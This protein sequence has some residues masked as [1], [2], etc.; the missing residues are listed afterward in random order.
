MRKKILILGAQSPIARAT[1]AEFARQGASLY[2]AD[3]NSEEISRIA[4]DLWIRMNAFVRYGSFD[5]SEYE[6]HPAF[7]ASVVEEMDGIDGVVV[8]LDER[9]SHNEA[10]ERFLE[11]KRIIEINYLGIVSVLTAAA[12]YLSEERKG[13]IIGVTSGA[14]D[15]TNLG[16]YLY[17]SAKN[18]FAHFLDGLRKRLRNRDVRVI[19]V[20]LKTDIAEEAQL[21]IQITPQGIGK[22][23]AL[24]LFRKPDIIVLP[25]F[26]P[27]FM[28]IVQRILEKMWEYIK[29]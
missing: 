20:K 13:F 27:F 18:A 22:T 29:R 21:K 14:G 4:S 9:G 7:F 26:W 16:N 6:E 3:T 24:S 25:S 28:A 8:A 15:R 10:V 5:A 1:A 19:T 11:A 23:I 17:G 2:L 12:N